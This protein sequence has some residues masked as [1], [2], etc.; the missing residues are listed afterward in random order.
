VDKIYIEK[1]I[2]IFFVVLLC[3]KKVFGGIN[4]SVKIRPLADK[5]VVK[6]IDE[7][8]TTSGGI[9]IPDTAREK[10]QKGE[11]IAVGPGKTLENGQKEP[12]EVKVGDKVIFAKYGG[13]DIKI[14]TQEV[15][16]LSERDVLGIIEE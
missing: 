2:N 13:T 12:L 10:P 5:I 8:E 4:M 3:S 1:R 6:V 9:F 15:K 14:G 16:I 7:T 11:V